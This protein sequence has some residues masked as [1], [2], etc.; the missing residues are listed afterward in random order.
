VSS[1][2]HVAASG[3]RNVLDTSGTKRPLSSE[4]LG[5]D[6]NLVFEVGVVSMQLLRARIGRYPVGVWLALL[7]LGVL[8]CAWAMQAYS[9]LDW[10]G[11]VDLG[12]QNERFSG[13][14]AEQ[15]W[16]LE[17]WGV[18]VADM[19]WALPITA[20]ACVGVLRLRFAGLAFGL[21]A[22]S[23][24][25][26]FP[27]FFA[28]QRWG[29]FQSTALFAV[30]FFTIPSLLGVIGLLANRDAFKGNHVDSHNA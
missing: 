10:N 27:I 4:A 12:L 26:Y 15:A 9:L 14:P 8:M 18:A 3:A 1:T 13:G 21:M 29:T 24:G 30:V 17:S 5:S 2:L 16:A 19:L 25:V 11:A 22:L 23:I 7:G 6:G 20:V 28:F